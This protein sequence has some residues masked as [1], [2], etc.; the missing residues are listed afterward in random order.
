MNYYA[1][2]LSRLK[3][4]NPGTRYFINRLF[5]AAKYAFVERTIEQLE[6]INQLEPEYEKLSLAQMREKTAEFRQRL[7][8][9][10]TLDDLL[11]EAFALGREASKRTTSLRHFD[12]Q[13]IGGVFL[14]HGKVAEMATGEGKTLVA[15]LPLYL[16]AL[17]GRGSHL[18]TVNDYLAKRDTQ[19]MGPIY[20][21]LG[22]S[23]GC[24][25]SQRDEKAPHLNPGFIFDPTFLPADS[26]FLYLRPSTRQEAYRCD[27]TYGV[28]N[29]FGFD[30]L[31]DNM[32]IRPEDQV[33]REL[34]YAIVDEVDSIL[35][36]E[37]RTPLI[38]SGPAEESPQL[39]FDIDKLVRKLN[40]GADYLVDEE[41][42]TVSLSDEG[43]RKCERLLSIPN[44]YDGL[45][46]EM[47]HH[48][49]QAL[50]AHTFFKRDKEYVVKT[51]Q[52]VIV[53]E[54][55]G[56]LMPGRRWSDGLHQAV[57]AKEGV[58]IE[59]ENQTLATIS[60]QNYFKLYHK[61]AGMT[62]TAMTEGVEFHEIYKL[63]V[64]AVPANKP[65]RRTKYDD[66]IYKSEKEKFAAIQNEIETMYK[67]ERPVLVGTISIEKAEKLSRML[68][69]RNIPHQVLHG[70]NHEAEA[71]IIAQA[72]RPRTVT[73]ATQ[74]A[75]RGVDIIL[76]GNP[77]ILAREETIQ[78]IRSRLAGQPGQKHQKAFV[79]VL[80]DTEETYKKS[81]DAV[82]K[83]Y[84][85]N[86]GALKVALN[87]KEQIF[88]GIDA[89]AREEF[90]R[91][92]FMARSAGEYERQESKL[93]KLK[94]RYV[95]AQDTLNRLQV[96]LVD[97][98]EQLKD[99][100]EALGRTFREFEN[101]KE[102]LRRKYEIQTRQNVQDKAGLF[103]QLLEKPPADPVEARKVLGRETAA[104]LAVIAGYERLLAEV[105]P[106]DV[107][108]RK[109]YGECTRRGAEY[110]AELE[111]F[112]AA[113]AAAKTPDQSSEA[114]R[115]QAAKKQAA[116]RPYMDALENL[117]QSILA[118]LAGEAFYTARDEYRRSLKDYEKELAPYQAELAQAREH[119]EKMRG[120]LEQEWQAAREELEKSPQEFKALFDTLL[121][122]YKE[123]WLKDH[124]KV[125]TAG[126]LHIIG[127]ERYEARRIDNQLVGRAGRQG[128]P[129]SSR[130]YLSLEDDL[131][132]IFGSERLTGVMASLPEGEN[133]NHP[134]ITRMINNAQKKVEARN[135]EIRKQ[136]LEFDNVLN[137]QRKIVYSLR[138]D[139]LEGHQLEEYIG[140]FIEEVVENAF[141]EFLDEKLRPDSWNVDGLAVHLQNVF[142]AAPAIEKPETLAA[143]PAWRQDLKEAAQTAA[144]ARYR[145]KKEQIGRFFPEIR[146]IIMLQVI[147]GRWRSHLRTLDELREGIGL[148]AYAQ[149]DP[150]VA[151]K[152][153]GYQVFQEMLLGAHEEILS[154]L[155]KVQISQEPPSPQSAGRVPPRAAFVHRS[156][157]QFDAM[158]RMP[159]EESTGPIM[160]LPPPEAPLPQ[161]VQTVRREP[162]V[163]RNDPC[164]C[165]S[166]KKYKKC[167]GKSV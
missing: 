118:S 115:V 112:S 23:V 133:I 66:E 142:G 7:A 17:T 79:E 9:G 59:S 87:E 93:Q 96:E 4:A 147:D 61:I 33:Q 62:G 97:K 58:R 51:G 100:K 134:M 157:E 6:Q 145:E 5:N 129:G 47:V 143:A 141:A 55:T 74:M 21:A 154:S 49:G 70:K 122:K 3:K 76:G 123:P 132:R 83:K 42:Q 68:R 144:L 119:H 108:D 109:E 116:Y 46:T 28:G 113:L 124:E 161:P 39:Y 56:R 35:I 131:L 107:K 89:R 110:R 101:F 75:G 150:L 11:V 125:V 81:L 30:Y 80:N 73:I 10:E 48:I 99:P 117:E 139:I 149:K 38:I 138:Q 85:E 14:H 44:L 19:W 71:T 12:V 37:A 120:D 53:D 103:S 102:G 27:I 22:L 152:N 67:T 159:A 29:E 160:D 13:I 95:A 36:D 41:G 114:I 86:L 26:R 148:R 78:V 45:H 164:P 90:E 84:G 64:I 126:G 136:L 8:A 24:I 155:F 158:A 69:F 31:R 140:D 88:S 163:G 65:M 63:D 40:R 50:R 20:H 127:S 91:R 166:G 57:E 2:L 121:T 153:E 18:V 111:S 104:Y 167:C 162:K 34:N 72:G 106:A 146:K 32:T 43:L 128:D 60:F 1:D 135:F 98:P 25:I 92:V 16:N 52:V 54:F 94:E 105:M 137:D 77:E 151:Y 15:T 82:E 165:G 156:M 130:Y